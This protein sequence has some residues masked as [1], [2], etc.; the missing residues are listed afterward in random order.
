MAF[1]NMEGDPREGWLDPSSSRVVVNMEHPLFKKYESVMAAR[2]Q[3]VA[4]VVTTVLLKNAAARKEMGAEE[5]LD[6]Q[7]RVLT[8]AK[9][10]VW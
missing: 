2:S 4:M 7:S 8:M 5:V 10:S 9:D 6:M 1:V 3:R